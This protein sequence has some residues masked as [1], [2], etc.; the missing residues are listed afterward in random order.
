[1]TPNR[2][3]GVVMEEGVVVMAVEVEMTLITEVAVVIVV[4]GMIMSKIV[5]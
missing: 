1:M 2:S 5:L 4:E 3:G